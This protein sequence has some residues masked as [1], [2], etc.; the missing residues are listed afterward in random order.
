MILIILSSI[1]INMN[2]I[3]DVYKKM[4]LGFYFYFVQAIKN[5]IVLG[6]ILMNR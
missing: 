3:Q 2:I 5:Q 4:R 1:F 6:L